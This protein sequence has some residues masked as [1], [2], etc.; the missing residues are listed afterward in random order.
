MPATAYHDAMMDELSPVDARHLRHEADKRASPLP[1]GRG[2]VYQCALNVPCIVGPYG[3]FAWGCR[4][5]Q[6]RT[7]PPLLT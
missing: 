4:H 1:P 6:S 5:P 3:P 7:P 2:K